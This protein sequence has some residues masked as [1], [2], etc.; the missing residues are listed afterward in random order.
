MQN[1]T[2][3]NKLESKLESKTVNHRLVLA[4]HNN[5][6]AEFWLNHDIEKCKICQEA[7]NESI[8]N[9]RGKGS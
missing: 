6:S 1:N 8:K 9:L 4:H 7:M 3:L 2:E 5:L